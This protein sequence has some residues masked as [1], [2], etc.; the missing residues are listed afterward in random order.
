MRLLGEPVHGAGHAVQKEGF[1][2]FLA[3]VA[4][5][6][7]DQFFSLGD[8]QCGE[9]IGKY[10]LQRAAQ[11]DVEEVGEVS[12]ADVVVVWRIGGNDLCCT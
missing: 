1:G 10:R 11:P 6:R 8:R 7:G 12:V 4:V 2:R 5:G 9:Q 3:A